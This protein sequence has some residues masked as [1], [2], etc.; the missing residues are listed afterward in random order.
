MTWISS[1][2]YDQLL[3]ETMR[4]KVAEAERALYAR[5]WEEEKAAHAQTSAADREERKALGEELR[6]LRQQKLADER[7]WAEEARGFVEAPPAPEDA[8]PDDE[9]VNTTKA[10]LDRLDEIT[11]GGPDANTLWFE[12]GA[13]GEAT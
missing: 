8:E 4:G 10:I 3:D 12:Q 1:A 5:L 2:R 11:N 7:R 13:T 6:E 9:P